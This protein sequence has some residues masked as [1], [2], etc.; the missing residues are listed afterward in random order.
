MSAN[1]VTNN[2]IAAPEASSAETSKE[3]L[4]ELQTTSDFQASKILIGAA[5]ENVLASALAA[6]SSS[7]A[8]A[9]AAGLD[10]ES[11]PQQSVASLPEKTSPVVVTPTTASTAEI[12]SAS[13]MQAEEPAGTDDDDEDV[14][15]LRQMPLVGNVGIEVCAICH[16]G[17]FTPDN[18]IV[19]CEG[20]CNMGYHQR[21][22]GIE[23]VPPGDEPWYCDLCEGSVS[24][25]IYRK[26]LYCCHYKNERS[27][28]NLIIKDR[29]NEHHFIHVHCAAFM[30]FIDTSHIPFT[31]DVSKMKAEMSKCCFC[32]G[33]F[34][35]QLHCSHK[36]DGAACETTFHPMCAIR[37]KFLAPPT[38]YNVKYHHFLCPEH[39]PA[40]PD[41]SSAAKKRRHA[42]TDEEAEQARRL[43]RRQSYPSQAARARSSNYSPATRGRPL[44]G[45]RGTGKRGR[46]P[47]R[48]RGVTRAERELDIVEDNLHED[49]L[50][51][52]EEEAERRPLSR[53]GRGRG[54]G[55]VRYIESTDDNEE[56]SDLYTNGSMSAR[57]ASSDIVVANGHVKTPHTLRTMSPEAADDAEHR[58]A[59][60]LDNLANAAL[61]R[62]NDNAHG[63]GYNENKRVTLTFSGQPGYHHNTIGMVND[64]YGSPMSPAYL[65]QH[66]NS[67]GY[68]PSGSQSTGAYGYSDQQRMP[69]P[70]R[71]TIRI[72]PFGSNNGSPVLSRGQ[73]SHPSS[74]NARNY[75]PSPTSNTGISDNVSFLPA[76]AK[77]SA[78]QDRILRESH[79]MLQKQAD[80]LC[81]I[82]EAI[83]ELSAHPSRQAQ[84]A[85]STIS[86]LSALISGNNAQGNSSNPPHSSMAYSSRPTTA[87]TAAHS[88]TSPSMAQLPKP[89]MSISQLYHNGAGSTD[90]PISNE[91][92][93]RYPNADGMYSSKPGTTQPPPSF[94]TRSAMPSLQQVAE[95]QSSAGRTGR[96]IEAEMD[97]L[98]TNMIYLLKRV[99]MPQ[100]LLDMLTSQSEGNTNNSP[101]FT[102]LVSDLKRLGVLSKDNLQEYLRVFVRNLEGSESN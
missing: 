64:R 19:F 12:T 32:S 33:R 5:P 1:S 49:S 6:A 4:K 42:G 70:K 41:G 25:N 55:R 53:R 57:T 18:L 88:T 80:V 34:G 38:V 13:V 27:A 89:A 92:T 73:I 8:A 83:S 52:N 39:S 26:N 45:K 15:I 35:Y 69:P 7:A 47:L 17:D 67:L 40:A 50:D 2:A 100:I 72:K 71:P 62:P 16:K 74:A 84:N 44:R 9:A 79:D 102:S 30:P 58:T 66:R 48:N 61:G 90:R 11:K 87:T 46:P 98:K 65:N 59:H 93:Y 82:Q 10:K 99:N 20:K 78:E 21:C 3:S 96:G 14:S 23:K 81:T 31:T 97:E 85:M 36:Q 75:V 101:A 29:P 51:D 77:L 91:S 54:R 43:T 76:S 94:A 63:S 24:M 60:S 22:Y 86:S 28:R 37:F 68:I 56:T 95:A